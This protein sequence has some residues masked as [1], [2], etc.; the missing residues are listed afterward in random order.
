MSNVIITG[1][2]SGFGLETA[3]AFARNGDRVYATMREPDKAGPL[4]ESAEAE[5]L[6]IRI[7]RLDVSQSSTF[8]D[9]FSSVFDEA[10]GIDV[11]INNAGILHL[12]AFEDLSEACIR[13][14]METNCIGPLLLSRAVLPFLR[15]QKRGYIITISSL[16]GVAGLPGDVS[17]AASKFALEGAMEALRHE[18]D[19]WG[20]KLALVEAGLYA[21]KIFKPNQQE[22]SH[23][24]A[25]YP[26]ES[27]YTPLITAKYRE[28]MQRLPQA[29]D[30][31]NLAK[32]LIKIAN[33]DGRQFRWPADETARHV[34]A[35]LF[36][37]SDAERDKFLREVSGTD[38]WS[39]GK[40][41][42]KS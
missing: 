17:Y 33:S 41:G 14:V 16:S 21:T 26:R 7:R 20:I 19:R 31:A 18:V 10:G 5:R 9:F 40:D 36:A 35:T 4:L 22:N 39:E 37:Q 3:L 25:D 13:D 15:K 42:P 34:L 28:F 29:E 11:L 24:P 1:S 30:P 32:L 6:D 12:G 23:L 27:P 2:N 8:Q 38:W